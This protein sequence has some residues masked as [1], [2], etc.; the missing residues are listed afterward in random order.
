MSDLALPKMARGRPTPAAK[1]KFAD[2]LAAWCDGITEINS[3]LDFRVSSRGWCYILE[4][5][6]GLLK[7]DFAAAQL[8]INDCRKSGLLP[9]D[10]C[11]TDEGRAADGI[12]TLDLADM[13]TTADDILER[14]TYAHEYYEP[15]SFWD[16]QD[17]Y[18]EMVT[19][20]IDLKSLF[21]SMCYQYHIPITNSS[22]WNDINSRA[23]IMKRFAAWEAK[24]KQ[25]VLLYCGDHD[26]GGLQISGFIRSNYDD[27]TNAVGWSPRNLII[28]RFGLDYDFIVAQG[29]TWIDN[30]ET[31]GG[32]YPLNDSRHNDH[33]Q[34][35]VQSYLEQFGARKCE[36][37]ALVTRPG[38]GREL[39]QD[40]ILRHVD[41]DGILEYDRNLA[42]LREDLGRLVRQK[43]A[44]GELS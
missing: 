6:G 23:A 41:P 21:S 11:S 31:G 29:L 9:L 40:A 25:C 18:V 37:N 14:V 30:L 13:G 36:A 38:A 28:E 20:K 33:F 44:D 34:S 39:C 26:P 15:I 24:G 10:I 27:L 35:Y 12:R 32:K 19:E 3:R 4:D 43:L 17:K 5:K 42:G 1:A 2:D 22:G 8:L 16:T 7:G